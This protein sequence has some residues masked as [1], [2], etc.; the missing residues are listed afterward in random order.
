MAASQI[1]YAVLGSLWYAAESQHI[2]VPP[3]RDFVIELDC[4]EFT[5]ESSSV[6]YPKYGPQVNAILLYSC[7][8]KVKQNGGAA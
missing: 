8:I 2:L 4:C 7:V 1:F 5:L 3:V 6:V